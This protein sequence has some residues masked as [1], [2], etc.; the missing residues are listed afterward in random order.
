MPE[1]LADF[2]TSLGGYASA[3]GWPGFWV[4]EGLSISPG[5]VSNP[6]SRT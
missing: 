2:I 5:L 3:E 6:K 4:L 1:L